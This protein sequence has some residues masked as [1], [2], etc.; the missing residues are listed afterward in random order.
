MT[1]GRK[2][3]PS[4]WIRVLPAVGPE[5]GNSELTVAMVPA[6]TPPNSPAASHDDD[7]LVY[8]YRLPGLTAC[9]LLQVIS[10]AGGPILNSTQPRYG[11]GS[12]WYRGKILT[13]GI[14]PPSGSGVC[15]STGMITQVDPDTGA[16]IELVKGSGPDAR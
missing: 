3:C 7:R 11:F 5:L 10:D 1:P 12:T 13:D 4:I 2:F 9:W 14:K 15:S 6:P 16:E 8:S